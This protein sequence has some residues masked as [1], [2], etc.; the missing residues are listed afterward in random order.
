VRW[1]VRRLALVQLDDNDSSCAQG[2]SEFGGGFAGIEETDLLDLLGLDALEN[3][4]P[5]HVI[6]AD[7]HR[8]FRGIASAGPQAGSAR[9]GARLPGPCAVDSGSPHATRRLEENAAAGS[10]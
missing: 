9:C 7:E 10:E 6:V 8:D 3:V 1:V 4:D 5:A 2:H